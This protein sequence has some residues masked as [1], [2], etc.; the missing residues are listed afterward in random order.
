MYESKFSESFDNIWGKF[1]LKLEKN[2]FNR[3]WSKN[4]DIKSTDKYVYSKALFHE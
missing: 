4:S 2:P 3:I 1:S